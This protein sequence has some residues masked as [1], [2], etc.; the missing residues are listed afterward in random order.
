VDDALVTLWSTDEMRSQDRALHYSASRGKNWR[1][2]YKI[3]A[4]KNGFW[5]TLYIF[6]KIVCC[7]TVFIS[8][9]D[10]TNVFT[11]YRPTIN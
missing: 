2:V 11:F 7:I 10:R 3:I 5:P 8:Q 9:A 6:Y 4:M 1:R